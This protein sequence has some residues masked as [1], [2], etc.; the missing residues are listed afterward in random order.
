VD[1]RTVS[2]STSK[3]DYEMQIGDTGVATRRYG[4][5]GQSWLNSG[6]SALFGVEIDGRRLTALSA[7][8]KLQNVLV[9]DDPQGHRHCVMSFRSSVGDI[10]IEHHIVVYT[11]T[12]LFEC[13]QIVTNTGSKPLQ[14]TRMDSFIVEVPPSGYDLLYF[15]SAWGAEFEPTHSHLIDTLTLETRAGRSSKGQHPWFGLFR[16]GESVL[17]ASVMWS[18]NWVFRFEP[19]A[20]GGFEISGGLHDW[21]FAKELQPGQTVE[22]ARV[23]VVLGTDLD[24]VSQQYARAGSAYWYP[25]NALSDSAPVEWNHWWSYEDDEISGTVFRQNVERAAN[26]GIEVCTLDAG[27]FGPSDA[28]TH[29][30]DYRGDWHIVNSVRFPHGIRPVA[31]WTHEQGLKFGLWCEIEGLGK[32]AQLADLHPEYVALR[33]GDRLGYVCFGNPA[34]QEW[35]YQTLCRLIGDYNCDWIKLDFNLDPGAGCNRTDHGHGVGDGLY[36]HYMGYYQ[37]LERVRQTF[38]DVILENCSSGGMR[39]DLGILRQTHMTFLSDPDWPVHD[40]QIFWGAS[41][42]LAPAAC[43]HWSYSEW[44]C[45]NH[46]EQRFN[47]HNPDLKPHQLDFY[48]RVGMLGVYGLSQKLP[49]LPQWIAERIAYHHHIYKTYVRRF[50]KEGALFRLTD[51]PRRNGEGERW[52]GFQYSMTDGSEHLLFV[53]R[54][55]GAEPERMLA[56]KRL[57]ENRDYVVEWLDSNREERVTGH[58]LMQGGIVV[59]GLEEEGSLLIWLH[60]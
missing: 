10:A 49:D 3:L 38:P 55:S 33:D 42:M 50:I 17:S 48:T 57:D 13:W 29:W 21:A 47:P 27:W 32:N 7:D 40:L 53:F 19:L 36:E 18:G 34:A 26:L 14:V 60:L 11:S 6:Q 44:C 41:T 24:D 12:A 59:G 30:H 22:S 5:V 46:P 25:R 15:T 54:L 43:L 1:A 4:L 28:G 35:A 9:N 52:C 31:D 20:Q 37:V 2:L 51:Q 58:Q 39:I 8:L 45:T 16:D 56:L 23:V